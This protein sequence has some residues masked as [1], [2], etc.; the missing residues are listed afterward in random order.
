MQ[1]ESIKEL[2][3]ALA[4]AQGMLDHAKKDVKNEYFKSKYADLASCI[5]A[6]KQA[7]SE[8][9]LAVIQLTDITD[10]G[11]I[12]RT[13]LMHSSGEWVSGIY[14]IDPVKKD[15]QGYGS[16]ITYA[17]RYAF[18]AITGVA[19]DDDDGNAAAQKPSKEQA[20]DEQKKYD[21][22]LI[23]LDKS[24]NSAELSVAKALMLGLP[25]QY[26]KAA[27][28]EYDKKEQALKSAA[29]KQLREQAKGIREAAQYADR[30][31]DKNAEMAKAKELD[32]KADKLEGIVPQKTKAFK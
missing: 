23:A 5:D 9:G 19:A 31:E 32:E 10:Y 6:A 2:A 17:R 1:S 27:R 26:A 29:A 14:P 13:T 25:S 16:A 20:I 24:T 28:Q 4:K 7:L 12:L 22:F 8:N 18:C 3:A 30:A 21:D 11:L 15:P